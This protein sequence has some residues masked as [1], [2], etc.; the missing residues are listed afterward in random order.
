MQATFLPIC[1]KLGG[2]QPPP[3]PPPAHRTVLTLPTPPQTLRLCLPT[4]AGRQREARLSG[5]S[6]KTSQRMLPRGLPP[7]MWSQRRMD[8]IHVLGHSSGAP[9]VP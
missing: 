9:V 5:S 2:S 1:S 8:P 4:C 7:V 6:T 3:A